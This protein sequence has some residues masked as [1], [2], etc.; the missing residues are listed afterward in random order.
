MFPISFFPPNPLIYCSLLSFNSRHHFFPLT[1]VIYIFV[2]AYART[3][4]S[5][6]YNV[7]CTNV[8]RIDNLLLDGCALP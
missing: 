2:Y 8:F 7:P 5:I 4:F 1:A 3:I 6:L